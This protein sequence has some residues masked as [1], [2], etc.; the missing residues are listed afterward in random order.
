MCPRVIHP[1]DGAPQNFHMFCGEFYYN[2]NLEVRYKR[3]YLEVKERYEW[4]G[5]ERK[6]ER[7][8]G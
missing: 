1:S 3:T 5:R 7:E 8:S 4:R 2:K 6:R